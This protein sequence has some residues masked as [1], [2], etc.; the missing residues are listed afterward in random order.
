MGKTITTGFISDVVNGIK[1]NCSLKCKNTNYNTM[2]SRTVSFVTMHYTGNPNPKDIAKNEAEYFSTTKVEGSAHFFVD[3]TSIFQSVA[4]KDKAWHCGSKTYYNDCRNANSIGIEMCC[5]AGNYRVSEKTKEN[6][7]H[8]CAHICKMIG[9]TADMVEQYVCRHY[10]VTHKECPAQMAGENNAEWATFKNRVKQ[11]LI[12][13]AQPVNPAPVPAFKPYMVRI[14]ISN[15]NIRKGPGTNYG[16][17]NIITPGAYTI[18][19]VQ[20][21]Q[22][23]KNGWGKLKSG[24][25]WI[26]LD[27][28]EKI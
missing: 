28:A 3:D 6:A 27:Y 19:E 20:Q 8:L 17:V 14:K 1:I 4:L 11:I 24:V 13:N 23:S 16:V 22:G 5:T 9:I 21:G 26:S 18:V 7:A 12:G 2:R 25:G 15:L 10:D